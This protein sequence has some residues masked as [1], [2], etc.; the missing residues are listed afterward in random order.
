MVI[1]FIAGIMFLIFSVMFFFAPRVIVKLSQMG[2]KLIF[3]DYRYVSHRKLSGAVL[4]I[5]SAVMF[6]LGTSL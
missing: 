3:T 6:Y 5:M 4:L 2:N 1:F